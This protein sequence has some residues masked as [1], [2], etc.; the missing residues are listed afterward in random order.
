[1]SPI[2][3]GEP[4]HDN[5]IHVSIPT[6]SRSVA[7]VEYTRAD[8]SLHHIFIFDGE[9]MASAYAFKALV[10][11]FYKNFNPIADDKKLDFIYNR[12]GLGGKD[13]DGDSLKESMANS[14]DLKHAFIS[15]SLS[16]DDDMFGHWVDMLYGNIE[17]ECPS[18]P[19]Q[20]HCT[21]ARVDITG[22]Y[23]IYY[24]FESGYV[25]PDYGD[26]VEGGYK[27]T[28]ER[29]AKDA[30]EGYYYIIP[31]EFLKEQILPDKFKAYERMF[32][33]FMYAEKK[34][35]MKWYQSTFFRFILF[36][37]AIVVAAAVGFI[38]VAQAITAVAMQVVNTI[39]AQIDPRLAA[40]IGL[41]FAL[42]SMPTS[43]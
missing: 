41:A 22:E 13:E 39:I 17:G 7:A 4:D 1:M 23:E 19:W 40:I 30:D 3:D 18:S 35:K 16:R 2:T 26:I 25:D 33:M 36:I 10:I 31:I 27:I 21:L 38:S 6:D 32:N 8:E 34:V 24:R 12:F 14:A 20:R 15:Y 42:Y 9:V 29:E 37:V 43:I 11:P 5:A 28:V